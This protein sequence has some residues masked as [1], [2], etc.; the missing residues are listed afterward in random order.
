MFLGFGGASP[1]QL[2]QQHSAQA[3]GGG[4][5]GIRPPR[6]LAL[7]RAGQTL[8]QGGRHRYLKERTSDIWV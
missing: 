6:L 5:R 8:D 3:R 7:Q 4:T 2:Q 1:T